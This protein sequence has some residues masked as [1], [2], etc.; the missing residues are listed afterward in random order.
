MSME[1]YLLEVI[2]G[3]RKAPWLIPLLQILSV[4]YRGVLALRNKGY[5]WGVF[6]SQQVG[7]PVVSIGNIVVGGTGKTPVTEMLSLALQEKCTLAILTRGFRSEME[8]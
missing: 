7:V 5:D 6:S 2:R 8:K 3:K 1:A 4:L